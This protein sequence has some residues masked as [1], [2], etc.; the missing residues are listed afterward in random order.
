MPTSS[1][2]RRTC[3][4]I[5]IWFERNEWVL[6]LLID[7]ATMEGFH[8]GSCAVI[9]YYPTQFRLILCLLFYSN[10]IFLL[11]VRCFVVVR[12]IVFVLWGTMIMLCHPY[13]ILI[14]MLSLL[15]KKSC[16]IKKVS[17]KY[18][19]IYTEICV[20]YPW[21]ILITIYSIL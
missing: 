12:V 9:E 13:I 15:E 21:Y 3:K 10:S 16:F 8:S 17:R 1:F 14:L 19:I 6:A 18:N 4:F 20:R 5:G 11:L 7:R 2:I